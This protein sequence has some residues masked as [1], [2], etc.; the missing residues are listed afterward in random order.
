MGSCLYK[1]NSLF[2]K[3]QGKYKIIISLSLFSV[4]LGEK[5]KAFDI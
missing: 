2:Y 1:Q 4:S 3:L 5:K